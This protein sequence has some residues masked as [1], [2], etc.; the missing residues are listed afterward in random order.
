MLLYVYDNPRK[1]TLQVGV[2]RVFVFQ[3]LPHAYTLHTQ[4]VSRV[5]QA[6]LLP[7]SSITPFHCAL[8]FVLPP[9]TKIRAFFEHLLPFVYQPF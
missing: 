4:F 8:G 5:S 6:N 1:R 3:A 7:W 9:D 2:K